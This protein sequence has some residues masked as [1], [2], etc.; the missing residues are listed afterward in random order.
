MERQGHQQH[1][2][3]AH[4]YVALV[5]WYNRIFSHDGTPD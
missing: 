2:Q 3:A 1:E 5:A 4:P